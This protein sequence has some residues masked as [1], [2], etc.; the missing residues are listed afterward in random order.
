MVGGSVVVGDPPTAGG[1]VAYDAAAGTVDG[2]LIG[3][4][5]A[6]RPNALSQPGNRYS[7]D[8]QVFQIDTVEERTDEFL[9][10]TRPV[11][12]EFFNDG[13]LGIMV[14]GAT[15]VLDFDGDVTYFGDRSAVT[16]LDFGTYGGIF[17]FEDGSALP[18]IV[19]D[20][21]GITSDEEYADILVSF[22]QG[23]FGYRAPVSAISGP[24]NVGANYDG[25][26]FL[27]VVA[28]DES[29]E[30][31]VGDI[32]LSVDLGNKS[33]FGRASLTDDTGVLGGFDNRIR[34]NLVDGQ[35]TNSFLTGRFIV[36]E[37]EFLQEG[38]VELQVNGSAF[39][40]GA[41]ELHGV[42]EGTI[43]ADAGRSPA[44]VLGGF[45]TL[46]GEDLSL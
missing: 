2:A 17:F 7:G 38:E 27:S 15:R 25:P 14:G 42:F 30:N 10:S 22:A 19:D 13:K 12:L 5:G 45:L 24:E 29:F 11:T 9:T 6:L 1:E 41:Q 21:D 18:A 20:G 34:M 37:G 36:P 26:A 40:P 31:M 3:R 43:G 8:I 39:G 33:V 46:R 4:A 16:V 44:A 23:A 35:L 28:T 32:F